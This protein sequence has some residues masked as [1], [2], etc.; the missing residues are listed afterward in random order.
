VEPFA[1]HI[2]VHGYELDPRGHVNQAVYLQYAELL[3]L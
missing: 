2:D 1:A 3:G